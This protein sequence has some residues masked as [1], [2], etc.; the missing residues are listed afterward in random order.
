MIRKKTTI[1]IDEGVLRSAK[2][3]AAREGKKEYQIVEEA[4]RKYLGLEVM[5]KVWARSKLKEAEAPTLAYR[6]IHAARK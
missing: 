4:L 5:E 3:M 2:I 1:Y 6:E